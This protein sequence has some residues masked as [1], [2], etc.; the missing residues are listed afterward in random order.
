M[1]GHS[2][3]NPLSCVAPRFQG[4]HD[5]PHDGESDAR[6]KLLVIG[7]RLSHIGDCRE[8]SKRRQPRK[9]RRLRAGTA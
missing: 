7:L 6:K 9:N 5:H 1:R 8:A 2:S 4:V 3:R